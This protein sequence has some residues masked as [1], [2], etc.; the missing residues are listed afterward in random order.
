LLAAVQYY[1][2]PDNKDQVL[3]DYLNKNKN[4]NRLDDEDEQVEEVCSF[5][6]GADTFLDLNAGKW[7]ESARV[8][9]VLQGRLVV[10]ERETTNS[11]TASTG[12]DNAAADTTDNVALKMTVEAVPGAKLLRVDNLNHI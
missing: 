7:K 4:K 5:V 8:L 9:D 10:L 3:I 6:M 11:T 2:P 12:D 1:V